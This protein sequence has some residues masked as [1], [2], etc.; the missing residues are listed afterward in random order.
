[1]DSALTGR[2]DFTLHFEGLLP[3]SSARAPGREQ[4]MPSKGPE[5]P[6]ALGESERRALAQRDMR[7]LWGPPEHLCPAHLCPHLFSQVQGGHFTVQMRAA[8]SQGSLC[9]LLKPAKP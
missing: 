2:Q 6:P 1:M 9:S 8:C 3:L 5:R 7:T 4:V